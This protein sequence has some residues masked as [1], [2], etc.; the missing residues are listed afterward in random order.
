MRKIL[1]TCPKKYDLS[2]RIKNSEPI[3]VLVTLVLSS[4]RGEQG[5][6]TAVAHLPVME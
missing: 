4:V 5:I 3:P 2:K 1:N 6:R